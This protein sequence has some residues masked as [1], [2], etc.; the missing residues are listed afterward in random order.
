M[1]KRGR[2]RRKEAFDKLNLSV[3][4][5]VKQR[6]IDLA[7]SRGISVSRLFEFWTEHDSGNPF[8]RSRVRG[9][10]E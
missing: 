7:L 4:A 3:S 6:A 2:P 10:R 9:T 8:G 1:N 5:A